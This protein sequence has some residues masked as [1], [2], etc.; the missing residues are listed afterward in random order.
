MFQVQQLLW[1]LLWG[2]SLPCQGNERA[3]SPRLKNTWGQHNRVKNLE[4]QYLNCMFQVQQFFWHLLWQW[5]LP[6]QGSERAISPWLKN[7]R[8]KNLELLGLHVSGSTISLAPT[9][10][11]ISS[12]PRGAAKKKS[13]FQGCPA[14]CFKYQT[15]K[16]KYVSKTKHSETNCFQTKCCP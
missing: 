14:L 11:R 12:L 6:F 13:S 7:N 4:L 3:I 16:E 5:F 2:G 8:V 15:F 1:H 10:G 9:Q